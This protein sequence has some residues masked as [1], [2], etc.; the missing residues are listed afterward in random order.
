MKWSCEFSIGKNNGFHFKN[1]TPL[2]GGEFDCAS[3]RRHDPDQVRGSKIE[4]FLSA[5]K[6]LP[7]L[8]DCY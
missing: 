2:D 7:V 1:K 3:L 6:R 8:I 5:V 4:V